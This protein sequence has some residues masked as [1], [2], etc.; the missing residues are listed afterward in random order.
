M[1]SQYD[2]DDDDESE[3]DLLPDIDEEKD[4]FRTKV[5]HSSHC[6]IHGI[7][8]VL[9]VSLYYDSR[10]VVVASLAYCY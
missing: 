6:N 9:L 5:C 2:D 4:V 3:L 10:L 8:T 1:T 7:V